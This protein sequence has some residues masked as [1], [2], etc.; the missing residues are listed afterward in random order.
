MRYLND[1]ADRLGRKSKDL[2]ILERVV[3]HNT[4][5][6]F[7]KTRGY[8][9]INLRSMWSPTRWNG[10]AD[11]DIRCAPFLSVGF[12]RLLIQKTP[13][14]PLVQPDRP[15]QNTTLCQFSELARLKRADKPFFVFAHIVAPHYPYVFGASGEPVSAAERKG[16]EEKT[17]W[18]NQCKFVNTKVEEL[19]PRLLAKSGPSPIIIIQGDHGL[20]EP[21][22]PSWTEQF[23]MKTKMRILNAYYFPPGDSI[24]L[25]ESI[26]P[27]NTF[28]IIFNHYFRTNYPILDD[29]SY[30]SHVDKSP[31]D[32]RD[33]T[34]LAR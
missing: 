19:I 15:F 34:D 12:L 2:Q 16:Q 18:V 29:R 10:Y 20:W 14:G 7:L 31:F 26:S 27:V 24:P 13:L 25:Y 5:M 28:R 33:V 8:S 11:Q 1:I 30:Y 32:I 22:K 6:G 4:V 23:Y 17:L 3:A 21:W 9:C